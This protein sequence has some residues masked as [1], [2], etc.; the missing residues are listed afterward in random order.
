MLEKAWIKVILI[1]RRPLRYITY[2]VQTWGDAYKDTPSLARYS[3]KSLVTSELVPLD[4]L[5]SPQHFQIIFSPRR[6]I[7]ST[8]PDVNEH[9]LFYVAIYSLIG[10]IGGVASLSSAAAQYTGALRASRRMFNQLLVG[11]VHAT[12]RWHDTTPQGLV[13]LSPLACQSFVHSHC[14]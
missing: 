4:G 9:P 10:L 12:M 8:W 5:S 7:T 14:H 3:F 13:S 11:V 1:I 6:L 2:F